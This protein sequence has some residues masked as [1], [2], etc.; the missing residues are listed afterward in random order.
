MHRWS[1]SIK[2]EENDHA[3][4]STPH[5]DENRTTD[6]D[7]LLAWRRSPARVLELG[8]REHDTRSLARFTEMTVTQEETDVKKVRDNLLPRWSR[9]YSSRSSVP[10]DGVSYSVGW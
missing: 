9:T 8:C 2:D 4:F 5:G 7:C 6:G 1:D 3:G 10:V